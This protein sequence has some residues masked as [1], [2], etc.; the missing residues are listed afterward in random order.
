MPEC[1][2]P[3]RGG[4]KKKIDASVILNGGSRTRTSQGIIVGRKISPERDF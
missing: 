2:G 3:V 4:K 1:P